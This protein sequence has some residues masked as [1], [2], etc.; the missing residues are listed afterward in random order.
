[1]FL[2]NQYSKSEQN[3]QEVKESGIFGTIAKT[4]LMFV[5]YG[6]GM[7]AFSGLSFRA[8]AGLGKL[9]TKLTSKNSGISKFL[10]SAAKTTTNV[11][12]G[13]AGRRAV[14]KLSSFVKRGRKTI[15]ESLTNI[16][17]SLS[18]D[19]VKPYIEEGRY[20]TRVS[21]FTEKLTKRVRPREL[22]KS[23]Y[24]NKTG[25]LKDIRLTSIIA[26]TK[27]FRK[28]KLGKTIHSLNKDLSVA[29][30]HKSM[31][32]WG[33]L[34][35]SGKL[36]AR[37]LRSVVRGRLYN[38]GTF[39]ASTAAFDYGMYNVM[40]PND[41]RSWYNPGKIAEWGAFTVGFDA[42]I[43]GAI[44]NFK[45]ASKYISS[46]VKRGMKN[47]DTGK[48]FIKTILS[49]AQ[50]IANKAA[51]RAASRA[52]DNVAGK[53]PEMKNPGKQFIN[54]IRLLNKE[55]RKAKRYFKDAGRNIEDQGQSFT[56]NI[57]SKAKQTDQF[58]NNRS[59]RKTILKTTQDALK[60]QA[61][62]NDPNKWRNVVNKLFDTNIESA[63]TKGN[64]SVYK[65]HGHIRMGKDEYNLSAIMPK[66][67]FGKTL[68]LF[69]DNL[70]MG[71]FNPLSLLG[72][73]PLSE[74]K[75][76]SFRLYTSANTNKL[77][78]IGPGLDPGNIKVKLDNVKT[79]RER[80]AGLLLGD[81][82]DSPDGQN[83]KEIQDVFA[84]FEAG[85]LNH[86]PKEYKHHI[87]ALSEIDTAK[88]DLEN[89]LEMATTYLDK[90][91][92]ANNTSMNFRE[93]DY[94]KMLKRGQMKLGE[95]DEFVMS[96]G[97]Q[98]FYGS[99][100]PD[101]NNW[102]TWQLGYDTNKGVYHSLINIPGRAAGGWMSISQ[103]TQKNNDAIK[104]SIFGNKV[105]GIIDQANPRPRRVVSTDQ[106]N[107]SAV[108]S[109]ISETLDFGPK[110][111][112]SIFGILKSYITKGFHP[113]SYKAQLHKINSGPN[114]F[115]QQLR[116]NGEDM[117]TFL[118][119]NKTLMADLDIRMTDKL[120]KKFNFTEEMGKE[121]K[122]ANVR[123]MEELDDVYNQYK[124]GN[125]SFID[126]HSL[127]H[128]NEA[129]AA[130]AVR[131]KA[132]KLINARAEINKTSVKRIF[133]NRN[134]EVVDD[135]TLFL[136]QIIDAK[137]PVK[138]LGE[139]ADKT[140]SLLKNRDV[141]NNLT[142]RTYMTGLE[143]KYATSLINRLGSKSR[144]SGMRKELEAFK[145]SQMINTYKSVDVN[146][147]RNIDQDM[148]TAM[149]SYTLGY[150]KKHPNSA[151]QAGNIV[152]PSLSPSKIRDDIL[153]P[154]MK[155]SP[156]NLVL[157]TNKDLTGKQIYSLGEQL[158]RTT[159]NSMGEKV[160]TV[161]TVSNMMVSQALNAVNA[162][163]NFIGLG[164]SKSAESTVGEFGKSLAFKRILPAMGLA[165][166][167]NATDAFL[168]ESELLEGTGLGE[169]LDPLM[170]N[171]IGQTRTA[172]A[173]V[174]DAIGV[175]STA[176][177]LEEIMP[178]S[179]NSPLAHTVRGIG[180]PFAGFALGTKFGGPMG[181]IVGGSIGAAMSIMSSGGPLGAL[182]KFDISKSREELIEEYSGRRQVPVYKGSGWMIST[183]P[184]EGLSAS[185]YEPSWY[186]QMTSQYKNTEVLYG[187]KAE[188]LT[189][190]FDSD[191]YF[192]KHKITRPYP[193]TEN[194]LAHTPLVGNVIGMGGELANEQE[195]KYAAMANSLEGGNLNLSGIKGIPGQSE[196]LTAIH[197]G[198]RSPEG[199]IGTQSESLPGFTT[200]GGSS[201][202]PAAIQTNSFANRTQE[203]MTQAADLMGLRGFA[204]ESIFKNMHGGLM[205]Y[206]TTPKLDSADYMTSPYRA[207]WDKNI[208]GM[209]GCFIGST[210]IKTNTRNK[211]IKD[212]KIG[213][214]VFSDNQYRK[215]I[216]KVIYHN[217]NIWCLDIPSIQ[218]QLK[219]TPDHHIPVY[220]PDNNNTIKLI[221]TKMRDIRIGDYIVQ[222]I[223]NVASYNKYKDFIY[224]NML[225]IYIDNPAYD[226]GE[227]DTVYDLTIENKH[228]YCANGI[229]VHN[230]NEILRRFMPRRKQETNIINPLKN[231]MPQWLTRAS[232]FRDMGTG[233]PFSKIDKGEARLPGAG[234]SA[235]HGVSYKFPLETEYLGRDIEEQIGLLTGNYIEDQDERLERY[236][237]PS[238][239]DAVV[240]QLSAVNNQVHVNR[241]SYD[242]GMNISSNLDILAGGTGMDIHV[243]SNDTFQRIGSR[244]LAKHESQM[245]ADLI[246]SGAGSGKVLYFN[247]DT[248]ATKS[249]YV[250]ANTQRYREDIRTATAAQTIAKKAV[251]EMGPAAGMNLA[252]AY[253]RL[254][255]LAI[256]GDVAPWGKEYQNT[257]RQVRKQQAA[258]LLSPRDERKLKNIQTMRS[259]VAGRYLL[260][261]YKFT[262]GTPV[263]AEERNYQR[264]IKSSYS[265][266]E[267]IV[268]GMWEKFSHMETP[269]HAKL[270]QSQ[271]AVEAYERREVYGKPIRTWDEPYRSFIRPFTQSALERSSP[272]TGAMSFGTAGLI[273]GGPVGAA[274]GAMLGAAYG[275]L[276][277]TRGVPNWRESEREITGQMDVVRYRKAKDL[278]DATGSLEAKKE[279]ENTMTYNYNNATTARA[280]FSAMPRHERGFMRQFANAGTME[281]RQRIME[282]IPEYAKPALESAWSGNP[283]K[284]E[285]GIDLMESYDTPNANWKG[286]ESQIK[287]DDIAVKMYERA[288]IDAY[289][290]GLG[291]QDQIR[292]M[293]YSPGI[294]DSFSQTMKGG[295]NIAPQIESMIQSIIPTAQVSAVS[296]GTN[297]IRVKI[298]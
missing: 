254:D 14:S 94:T 110:E 208:G 175:T 297:D 50:K 106:S 171:V 141:F 38:Y 102:K 246:M 188:S 202:S 160:G 32:M 148:E 89:T 80:R 24:I 28:S 168:D 34:R 242:M 13:R 2:P 43:R 129:D 41:N 23:A 241:K 63:K 262:R 40:T 88:K 120:T 46:G 113:K 151:K 190:M 277:G 240:Q 103:A 194:A 78:N 27:S 9:V 8:N 165:A 285:S 232:D 255:R 268:G 180:G 96:V 185:R 3:R 97:N 133:P 273:F 205:P 225:Y 196:S 139:T 107:A 140:S 100:A 169:G 189:S 162:T 204:A 37:E 252:N 35:N 147:L 203:A 112:R 210:N 292:R 216:N 25:E 287:S 223:E 59:A 33:V 248:G 261:E 227:T 66:N 5:A 104:P 127:G 152:D 192:E 138:F 281:E 179:V 36:P 22:P 117:S 266:P 17:K 176:K 70:T 214:Y 105:N 226:T 200:G 209:L 67:L 229:L 48:K 260:D 92:M 69:H 184:V 187:S 101:G 197:P 20:S 199:T 55:Y 65:G 15:D 207:Y 220:R 73:K 77:V 251:Q 166:G 51:P 93:N 231:N 249:T 258:G 230:T 79:A 212:I 288:G 236:M 158:T 265:L 164:F 257:L 118:N 124:S 60:K 222:P 11:P 234:Y 191:H 95:D 264:Y 267:R 235:L 114:N 244:P 31:G 58:V 130:V 150:M 134:V 121:F 111:Q 145:T 119:R 247:A 272:G 181:G 142:A 90:R 1:V 146:S 125:I 136:Q 178:G 82:K 68:R 278:Y 221:D 62:K 183:T 224:N 276:H 39:L 29:R 174:N 12:H 87:N 64:Y 99:R 154:N 245:N 123:H 109:R 239:Q 45:A 195:L 71:G 275:T 167:Y 286:W 294:P 177:Y 173:G 263:T 271:S 10:S 228:Y 132:R 159:T 290:Q 19:V 115:L 296:T 18:D 128:L 213:E 198:M 74:G 144:L 237:K 259:D 238:I 47:N 42:A 7:K 157:S 16:K 21:K 83:I 26:N 215:V 122:N 86:L 289:G 243:V 72:V 149:A 250:S 233:D 131:D 54:K 126:E 280:L 61:A 283:E 53:Y 56:E 155:Y 206:E 253:S 137:D 217:K 161:Q 201:Y 218:T 76:N 4:G 143:N 135:D 172:I 182:G 108:K 186:H 153:Y 84:K 274:G 284:L 282:I 163:A 270:L 6:V 279:M 295:Q 85:E 293:T 156:A 52:L 75:K 291:W 298:V 57:I 44:P 81:L 116:Q 170:A 98:M 219:G 30:K 269:V 49:R 211:K 193:V 91:R 256:L